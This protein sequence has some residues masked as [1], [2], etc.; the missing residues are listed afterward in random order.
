MKRPIRS[1][2]A[3]KDRP[4]RG[5]PARLAPQEMD[6]EIGEIGARGDGVARTAAG[7]IYLPYTLPDERVRARVSGERGEVGAI[8]SPSPARIAPACAHFGRCGGCQLQH[9][10][11]AAYLAWKRD[12]VVQ[13]LRRRGVEAAVA[14][15]AP[16]WGEGRRRAAFHASAAGRFGFMA[17]GSNGLIDI[18]ECPAL[19]PALQAKLPALRALGQAFAPG[20]GDVTI[21]ALETETGLD[22]DLKGAGAP[23]H[24]DAARLESAARLA[25]DA[26]LAR[27]SFNGEPLVTRRA[28]SLSMG[29][30][31]VI[32]PPG[33]FTQ[34]TRAGE[35]ALAALALGA[36]AGCARIA[37]LF[38]GVG[39]F[40]LR[41]AAQAQVFAV[42]GEDGLIAALKAG[43][44]GAGG[45]LKP[46]SVA[47]RD[48]LRAPLAALELKR[49]DG[50]AFD[51]PRSGA[52]LQAEQIAASKV[53][54]VAAISCDPVAFARDARILIDGGFALKSVAPIDQFRWSPHVEIVG[55]FSR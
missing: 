6:L 39:T 11:E 54:K 28:P 25:A 33:A 34:P 2:E 16:A 36:L 55:A 30:A 53:E 4:P 32:P 23:A 18:R 21:A 48:L 19:T 27:L 13:A 24:F 10:D 50:V 46:V 44:D 42:D 51:P 14:P 8:L 5:A 40:A 38:S 35:A 7:P 26:D 52:R 17:R 31:R 1:A 20:K 49:F 22:V 12:L 29:A 47:R 41:L 15:I 45:A 43:A 37:D 3:L 9:W